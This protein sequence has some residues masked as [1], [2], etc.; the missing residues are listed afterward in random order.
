LE[1]L[2]GLKLFLSVL[3]NNY[4]NKSLKQTK[5]FIEKVFIFPFLATLIFLFHQA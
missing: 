3:I 4:I 1:Y 2:I 5:K